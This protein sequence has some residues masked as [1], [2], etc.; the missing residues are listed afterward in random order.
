MKLMIGVGG[1]GPAPGVDEGVE[2][3]LAYFAAGLAEED[4]VIG[5]GVEGR[6]EVD[7]IDA[8][9]GE[10]FRVPEPLEVVPEVEAVHVPSFTG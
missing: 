9:V 4:V 2:L 6:L 5:V 10:L 7:Q 3:R 1:V 8:G